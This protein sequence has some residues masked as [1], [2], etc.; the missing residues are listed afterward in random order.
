MAARELAVRP[1]RLKTGSSPALGF[2]LVYHGP[3]PIKLVKVWAELPWDLMCKHWGRG[4]VTGHLISEPVH[5][6]G[7]PR[8]R[9]EYIANLR[10][11]DL[12]KSGAGWRPLNPHLAPMEEPV[13]LRKL[14]SFVPDS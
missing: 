11:P 4:G 2:E 8:L 13:F 1:F 5:V 12:R 6:D 7:K 14:S 3:R 9:R 10:A